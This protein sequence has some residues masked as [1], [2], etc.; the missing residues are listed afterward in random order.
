[1]RWRVRPKRRVVE[2]NGKHKKCSSR[3][4]N[5]G[6]VIEF[7]LFRRLGL[8]V[9]KKLIQVLRKNG[10]HKSVPLGETTLGKL[11]SFICFKD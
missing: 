1:M 2:R 4:D 5:P 3:R 8:G 6:K 10:K 7:Y 9:S 11:L